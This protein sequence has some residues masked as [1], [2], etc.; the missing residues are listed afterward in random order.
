[1]WGK[2][3]NDFIGRIILGNSLRRWERRDRVGFKGEGSG[4]EFIG[5]IQRV[6]DSFA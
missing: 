3:G 5:W 1:M 4:N 2:C 6:Q